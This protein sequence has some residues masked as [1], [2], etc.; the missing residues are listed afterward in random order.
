MNK[1]E[2]IDGFSKA[3]NKLYTKYK[4]EFGEEV[5]LTVVKWIKTDS[6]VS[7]AEMAVIL[8]LIAP[9]KTITVHGTGHGGKGL[10][11]KGHYSEGSQ[12][13]NDFYLHFVLQYSIPNPSQSPH[14]KDYSVDMV[15]QIFH[16]DGVGKNDQLLNSLGIE[17]DGHPG[18]FDSE[19]IRRTYLRDVNISSQ[20]G[21]QPFR[22]SPDGAKHRLEDY[23]LA[24]K[25]FIRRAIDTYR[26]TVSRAIKKE[27]LIL[28]QRGSNWR[29]SQPLPPRWIDCPICKGMGYFGSI[30][31]SFCEAYGRVRESRMAHEDLTI[32]HTVTCPA[33]KGKGES[34]RF[35]AGSGSMENTK[36]LTYAKKYDCD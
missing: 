16:A 33:C 15:V 32:Y 35:C 25:K 27:R 12:R 36:A 6:K 3:E 5:A 17:Y 31:C 23:K 34:C 7:L 13:F 4:E 21:I 18:H 2:K 22:I 14:A 19:N 10:T 8:K 1:Y 24:I 30:A 11:L 28:E 9:Y 20:A 26:E 29:L